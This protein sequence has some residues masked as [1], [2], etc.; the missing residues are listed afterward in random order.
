M[1]KKPEESRKKPCTLCG[2]VG[3]WRHHHQKEER[4]QQRTQ[5]EGGKGEPES[6]QRAQSTPPGNKKKEDCKMWA[7]GKCKK[8][9][10]CPRKHDPKKGGTPIDRDCRYWKQGHSERYPLLPVQPSEGAEGQTETSLQT[11]GQGWNV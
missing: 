3:H 6:R 5:K 2:G 9:K 11:V 7:V 10:D 1:K 8:G 4:P